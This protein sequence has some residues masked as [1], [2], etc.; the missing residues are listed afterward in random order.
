M[1][2]ALL[3]RYTPYL[4]ERLKGK[5]VMDG[6][7]PFETAPKGSMMLSSGVCFFLGIVRSSLMP[8]DILQVGPLQGG[9]ISMNKIMA[10]PSTTMTRC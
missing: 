8:K 5:A 9:R 3:S 6:V 10:T 1:A 4:R 2:E 7:L